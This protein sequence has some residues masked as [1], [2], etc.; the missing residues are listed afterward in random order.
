MAAVVRRAG[1]EDAGVFLELVC[2][3]A[4]YE[5]LPPPD[6][7]ARARLVEHG[8]GERPRFDAYLVEVE[9]EAV[10]YA[11]VFETYSSFLAQPTLYLEDLFVRPEARGQG[12]GRA[13][14]RHLAAEAVRRGCG[15][16]EWVVLGWNE[17]ARNVYRRIGAREL[18]EWRFCR[19]AGSELQA[20]AA[21]C[22]NSYS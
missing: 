10:G 22:D 1:R 20:L 8:F 13:L 11:I 6:A 14:L 5:R 2:A 7:E 21:E 18:E 17:L 16:M 3:L 4:E 19:L 15:R 12:A 9:G